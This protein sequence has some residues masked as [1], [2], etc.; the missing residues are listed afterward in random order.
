MRAT[1]AE[2][3]GRINDDMQ[4]VND[5]EKAA[6]ESEQKQAEHAAAHLKVREE[7]SARFL[8]LAAQKAEFKMQEKQRDALQ[9]IRVKTEAAKV[10]R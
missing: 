2:S 8:R 6:E 4:K 7:E 10:R 3:I 1:A 9:R 5:N